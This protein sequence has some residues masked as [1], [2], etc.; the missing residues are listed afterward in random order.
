MPAKPA[1][2]RTCSNANSFARQWGK[3]RESAQKE[4]RSVDT[5]MV[6]RQLLTVLMVAIVLSPQAYADKASDA[7]KHGVQAERKGD[8]DAAFT[9]YKQAYTSSPND[10]KYFHARSE[11]HTSE[12]QSLRHLVC[13]LL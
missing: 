4:P 3:N 5:A 12:L 6:N 10:A 1:A 2:A 13:R 8:F 7:F 9:Y 11:E